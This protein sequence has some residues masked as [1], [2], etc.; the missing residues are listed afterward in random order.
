[1]ES[2][3]PRGTQPSADWLGARAGRGGLLLAAGCF[4]ARAGAQA[5]PARLGLAAWREKKAGRSS[6]FEKTGFGFIQPGQRGQCQ[7]ACFPARL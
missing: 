4:P 5:A 7:A 6:Y 3:V 1:M 2:T